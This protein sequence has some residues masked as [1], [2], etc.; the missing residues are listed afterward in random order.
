MKTGKV[1]EFIAEKRSAYEVNIQASCNS[2]GSIK[3]LYSCFYEEV[4]F[5]DTTARL[6]WVQACQLGCEVRRRCE[7]CKP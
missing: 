2:I 4:G 6:W 3:V 7:L 5:M 1:S